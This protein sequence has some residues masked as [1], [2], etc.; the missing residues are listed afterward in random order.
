MTMELPIFREL[1]SAWFRAAE[2]PAPARPAAWP[3]EPS[4]PAA[5][6]G[7]PCRR[8]RARPPASGPA[9]STQRPD[10]V[11][12]PRHRA[13]YRGAPLPTTVGSPHRRPSSHRTEAPPRW[14][15]RDGCRW[16]SSFRVGWRPRP[17]SHGTTD[18][19]FGARS[20]LRVHPRCAKR[21]RRPRQRRLGPERHVADQWQGAGGMTSTQD[22]GWLL[23]NFA[24]RV[25]GVAHAI[26]VSADGLLLAV[27]PRPAARPCRPA[28][29]DRFRV[30]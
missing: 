21:P 10:Q 23:A 20:A 18:A 24:D 29:R 28:R 30:W 7:R 9:A 16:L 26:A 5:P 4:A 22:L 12:R 8:R 2:V 17:A 6:G 27:V 11:V 3:P 14:G 15:F 19:G 13:R 1:E 25:P